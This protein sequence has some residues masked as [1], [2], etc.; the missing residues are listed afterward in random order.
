[1]AISKTSDQ[2]N[3]RVG[4][5]HIR[6]SLIAKGPINVQG[7]PNIQAQRKDAGRDEI[8]RYRLEGFFHPCLLSQH[9]PLIDDLEC[10][11]SR[12]VFHS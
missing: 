7:L 9:Q 5:S 6:S 12:A 8:P 4:I 2:W 1:M 3:S 10:F 11:F